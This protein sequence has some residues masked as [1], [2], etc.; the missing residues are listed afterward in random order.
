MQ[1]FMWCLMKNLSLYQEVFL[2]E[3]VNPTASS[4]RFLKFHSTQ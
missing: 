1:E 4:Q 3:L 2:T